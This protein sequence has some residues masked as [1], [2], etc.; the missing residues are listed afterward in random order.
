LNSSENNTAF[1]T[2]PASTSLLNKLRVDGNSSLAGHWGHD[3]YGYGWGAPYASFRNLEVSSSGNYTNEPAML[4]IHQWGS[5]AAEFWKPQGTDLYLRETPGGGG[6]WFTR[7]VTS[8][9][10]LVHSGSIPNGWDLVDWG[11]LVSFRRPGPGNMA[12]ANHTNA[13]L[14]LVSEGAGAAVMTFHR[15]GYYG[16]NFGLDSDNWF[17]TQGWSA[18]GGYTPLRVGSVVVNGNLS[19]TGT[20]PGDNLG[21]HTATTTLN[22]NSQS[23]TNATG[24]SFTNANPYITASS[25]FVAPGGAYF[26]SGTVYFEAATQV[27]GGIQNDAGSYGGSVK[28]HDGLTVGDPV[29]TCPTNTGAQ[30]Y[31]NSGGIWYYNCGSNGCWTAHNMAPWSCSGDCRTITSVYQW[32]QV[33]HSWPSDIL[34]H[35]QRSGTGWIGTYWHSGC[36]GWQYNDAANWGI[37]NYNGI[38]PCGSNWDIIMY[39]A[40]NG[41][42][43]YLV[44]WQLWVNY[45]YGTNSSPWAAHGQVRAQSTLFA[46]SNSAYGDVA[47]YF[48]VSGSEIEPGDIVSIDPK[49]PQA[50]TKSSKAYDNLVAGV[51]SENPSILLNNP[52]EGQPIALTGRVRVKVSTENGNIRIGDYITSSTTSGVGMRADRKGV[53]VGRA[54]ENFSGKEAGKIWVL[55]VNTQ[56]DPNDR[57]MNEKFKEAVTI[58]GYVKAENGN[59]EYF[60]AFDPRHAKRLPDDMGPETVSFN[61][62]PF[63]ANDHLHISSLTREGFTVVTEGK[64]AGFYYDLDIHDVLPENTEDVQ[65][66]AS[67]VA[68]LTFSDG[69]LSKL[70]E[71]ERTIAN[72]AR[73]LYS[74]GRAAYNELLSVT[75]GVVNDYDKHPDLKAR[76]DKAMADF[77]ALVEEYP[78]AKNYTATVPAPPVE[79]KVKFTVSEPV[80]PAEVKRKTQSK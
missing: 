3:P 51:I 20:F 9:K 26:N 43:G 40:S 24:L 75:N 52:D 19:V 6:G 30:A 72:R 36:C 80:M 4:R 23:I 50:F 18:G 7:F 66:E 34:M 11:A 21:N 5:G 48:T 55:I 73:L 17:S 61:L 59:T 47:E 69:E 35:I 63:G 8:G 37:T 46:N 41:D 13:Q 77:N 56:F 64:C 39:D 38:D 25:Y 14:E 54:L 27:R 67:D 62:T 2:D 49:N 74:E 71:S 78:W 32:S 45:N 1:Y 65:S 10:Q 76:K 53:V 28:I 22:M 15:P 29:A 68:A 58:K 16:A 60:V 79:P 70:S 42:D 33:Y 57:V 12:S 44:S 31:Q